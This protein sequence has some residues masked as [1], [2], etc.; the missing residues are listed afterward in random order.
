YFTIQYHPRSKD[1]M[2]KK[3]VFILCLFTILYILLS[4]FTHRS[5]SIILLCSYSLLFISYVSFIYLADSYKL[6]QLF[7]SAFFIRLLILFAIPNLSDDVYRFIWDGRLWLQGVDAYHFVPKYLVDNYPKLIDTELYKQI[8]SPE[9]FTIYPPLNQLI[10]LGSAYFDNILYSILF[11][12]LTVLS[13]EIFGLL[14]IYK[15]IKKGYIS[16]K[17]FILY[18]FNPLVILEL[19]GNLHFE[20]FVICFLIWSVYFLNKRDTLRSGAFTGLAI[21]FKILPVLLLASFFKKFTFSKYLLFISIALI[22]AL[23]SIIPLFNTHIFT[24]I[25]ESAQLYFQ[26][27]EFNASIYY[28]VRAIG[29]K[30]YGYNIIETAGPYITLVG[31]L[32]ISIYNIYI[33]SK[34]NIWE[35]MLFS[36]FI[37]CLFSMTVH[38]WYIVPMI[39]FGSMSNYK[40]P[41]LWSFLIFFTYIGYTDQGFQENLIVTAIEY[42]LVLIFAVFEVYKKHFNHDKK[43]NAA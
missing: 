10:F 31:I 39:L 3:G 9:Y 24:G 15:L 13:A 5:D 11:I 22:T 17:T 7:F 28:L 4:Y 14:G 30:I 43:I 6:K 23:L 12:K 26:N 36:W 34:V 18:A 33:D 25:S 35:R 8:N 20:A 27:F 16:E 29:Y 41:V 2:D 42:I 37:Y 40:F 38:P 32:S 21:G 1:K 19:V